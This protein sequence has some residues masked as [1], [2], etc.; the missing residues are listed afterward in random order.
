M[1]DAHR[2]DRR[3]DRRLDGIVALVTGASRGIGAAVAARL[4]Q[5]GAAVAVTART[6]SQDPDA[7]LAGSLERT[8]EA[9]AAAG[10]TGFAVVADLADAEDRARIVPEVEAALGPVDV[11]VNNAAAALY[12][13]IVEIPLRRRRLVFEINLHAPVDLAQAV[14][15]GMRARRR[16]WIVNISSGTSRHPDPSARN[17]LGTTTSVYGASKAALERLTTGL[18]IEVQGDGIAVN[19]VSPVRAVRTEGA[20]AVLA[21]R[22]DDQPD[23]FEPLWHLEE[24]V[25]H[26]SSCEAATCTG[27]ILTSGGLLAELGI[28]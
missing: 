6:A 14:V 3:L 19:A 7:A 27:R 25:L 21:G 9:V 5:A 13:P 16:G 18:A 15:P 11:L 17:V 2:L 12:A 20:D 8:L 1:S 4:A 24:A 28:L 26:L 23:V 22:L 10:S